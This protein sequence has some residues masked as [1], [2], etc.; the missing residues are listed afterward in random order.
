MTLVMKHQMP[1][2]K[3]LFCLLTHLFLCV[4]MAMETQDNSWQFLSFAMCLQFSAARAAAPATSL[5]SPRKAGQSGKVTVLL[6]A[7][8]IPLSH[9]S[10]S[11]S[12]GRVVVLWNEPTM[13]LILHWKIGQQQVSANSFLSWPNHCICTSL[14][15]Y[16]C[17]GVKS[18]FRT[19]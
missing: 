9:S 8:G 17:K 13:H 14:T 18:D 7:A 3:Y 5:A 2:V 12:A 10:M 11:T 1:N 16:Y 6:N 15:R 4:S 19:K